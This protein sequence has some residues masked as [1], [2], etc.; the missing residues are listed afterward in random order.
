M[1][2][3]KRS[4]ILALACIVVLVFAGTSMGRGMYVE[5]ELIVK[6]KSGVTDKVISSINRKHGTSVI[7]TSR[8]GKFKRLYVPAGV[9]IEDLAY[10]YSRNPNVEYAEPNYIAHAYWTPNDPL[11]SYQWNFY[12]PRYGGI[13]I[14][15]AWAIQRGDPSVIVAVIDTGVAYENYTESTSSRGGRGGGRKSSGI[16]RKGGG[17]TGSVT[18]YY[19]APDLANT[20]FVAGYD[21]VNDDAHPNDDEGHG[22]HVTGTIAQST[23]NGIGVAGIAFNTSIMPV[24]VL[25]KNGSGT[26]ADI[27]EGIYFAANNGADV[28]NMSL[29]GPS[30]STTLEEALAYAYNK[31]VTIVAAAGNDGSDVIGYP[32]AYDA[33]VIAVGATRYDETLSYYSNYGPS[34]DIVAPGGDTKVDQNG[35]GYVD[36]ILQQT[37]G[38]STDDWG[39]FYYQGT[40]MATPHV[41]GVAALLIANGITGPDNVREALQSTAKDLGPAGWDPT[42]GWGRVDA[43]AALNY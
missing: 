4:L 38:S 20:N 28:I 7:S 16:T 26:Y 40:S 34:L 6:F 41:A 10:I 19:L 15:S 3:I 17:S 43:A 14:K 39:Y 8:Q 21:F 27:A 9:D 42:Y 5:N 12:N 13:N 29:G 22:T 32:A 31:G 24:K 1:K 35:D 37:F 36:G 25:D 2:I 23:N 11:F 18:A 30:P 33:Y